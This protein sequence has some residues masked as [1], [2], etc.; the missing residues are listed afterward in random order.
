LVDGDFATAGLMK[1]DGAGTYSIITG[2]SGI[3]SVN[4]G[5]VDDDTSL[6]TSAAI[7]DQIL[8][9]G[10][11]TTLGTVTSVAMSVPTGLTVAGSPIT[12]SGTLALTL[13]AG[14]SIPTTAK[15]T[16]WDTAYTNRWS[17]TGTNLYY[18]GG[19]VSI[20]GTG[21]SGLLHIKGDTSDVN[22]SDFIYFVS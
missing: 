10:Y 9:Y 21:A 15:Q 4:T 16:E 3:L 13:T 12:S 6:M 1:T 7:D 17:L 22:P 19:S 2:S 8:S 20:G 5:F 14:Y 11:S 18:S